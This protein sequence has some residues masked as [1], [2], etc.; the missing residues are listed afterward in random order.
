MDFLYCFFYFDSFDGVGSV[1][2]V[3]GI[4]D[5]ELYVLDVEDFFD[6]VVGGVGDF[7][8]DGVFFVE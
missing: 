6:G 2:D 3:G 1:V 5:V 8:D 7:V 4:D